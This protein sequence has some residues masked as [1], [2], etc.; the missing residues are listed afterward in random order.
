MPSPAAGLLEVHS[1]AEGSPDP[2]SLPHFMPDKVDKSNQSFTTIG[3]YRCLKS[4]CLGLNLLKL[5]TIVRLCRDVIY[6]SIPFR[7]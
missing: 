4:L 1:L 3:Q 5:N 7:L 6:Q 2:Q